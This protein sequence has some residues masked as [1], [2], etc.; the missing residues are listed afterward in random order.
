VSGLS[1]GIL[2]VD[3]ANH[4]D[5]IAPSVI[6]VKWG[7]RGRGGGYGVGE[8]VVWGLPREPGLSFATVEV[9]P[10]VADDV[11][12]GGVCRE[13]T[14]GGGSAAREEGWSWTTGSEY[15]Y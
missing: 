9:F 7:D 2:A 13:E 10:P 14:A 6:Y 4:T 11:G 8:P 5:P 15:H 1:D 12:F 3:H